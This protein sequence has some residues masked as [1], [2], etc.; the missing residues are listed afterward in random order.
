MFALYNADGFDPFFFFYSPS[1]P[2]RVFGVTNFGIIDSIL[3]PEYP[4]PRISSS[5]K[6]INTYFCNVNFHLPENLL[7][8]VLQALYMAG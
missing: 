4:V 2:L 3:N 5:L 1:Y 8:L 7:P 6:I